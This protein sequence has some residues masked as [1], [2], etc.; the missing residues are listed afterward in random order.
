MTALFCLP[1]NFSVISNSTSSTTDLPINTNSDYPTLTWKTTDL[2]APFIIIDLGSGTLSYDCVSLVG[3]NLRSTDTVRIRTSSVLPIT[4]VFD[5]GF[6]AAHSQTVPTGCTA[7]SI[8][9]LSSTRTERYVRID[10]TSPSNP[11]AYISM[12]RIVVGKAI[13]TEGVL[14]EAEQYFVDQSVQYSGIGYECYDKLPSL[15][16]WKISTSWITNADWQDKWYPFL[17]AVGR[18]TAFLFTP[19]L[20]LAKHVTDGCF[21]RN[22]SE[23]FSGKQSYYDAWNFDLNVQ[24]LAP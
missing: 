21:G 16:G 1:L 5:S 9:K 17:M 10:M 12:Q 13:T 22:Q 2:S 11:D 8:Y 4:A 7:K 19:N 14:Q 18:S 15:S 24:N 23:R 3:T 6:V 20:E